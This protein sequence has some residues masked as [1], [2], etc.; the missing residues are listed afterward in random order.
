MSEHIA[1]S[2]IPP[3]IRS[4][5]A[6]LR[7]RIRTYVWLEGLSL[8]VVWLGA[9]FWC[10]LAL[11]YLPVLAGVG[12]MP[13]AARLLLL[14]VIAGVFAFILYRWLF[15]RVFARL[16]DRSMAVL[17][18]RRFHEFG[19]SLIT[20]VELKSGQAASADA[21]QKMLAETERTA[22]HQVRSVR[23]SE[24]FNFRPLAVSVVVA[25]VFALTLGAFYVVNAS[26]FEIG[27]SRLYLLKE[28]KWPRKARIEVV[29]V[30]VKQA[31]VSQTDGSLVPLLNGN[32]KAAKG[33]SV[34]LVVRAD[35]SSADAHDLP[36]RGSGRDAH[37]HLSVERGDAHVRTQRRLGERD[38]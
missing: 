18:E 25:V 26:A 13:R 35:A 9:T 20:A 28:T 32:V 11:D 16:A 33:S 1:S 19:D 6:G 3:E 37:G 14:L 38:R 21:T 24:V 34:G 23:L 2:S 29:G 4:L 17:L 15:R 30:E 31:G 5:L 7:W 36:V 22:L 12:E 27:I 10:G 8:A